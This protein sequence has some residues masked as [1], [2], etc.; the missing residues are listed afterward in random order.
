M[1]LKYRN[2]KIFLKSC[3][4]DEL[5]FSNFKANGFEPK[6][7]IFISG[8]FS[9]EIMYR[10]PFTNLLMVRYINRKSISI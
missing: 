4:I 2:E 7:N 8:A 5:G 1:S 10:I 3:L 6:Y 9:T